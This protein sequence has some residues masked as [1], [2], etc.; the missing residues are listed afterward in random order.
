[1]TEH[2][3]V[4]FFYEHISDASG[5]RVE[6]WGK[7]FLAT[8]KTVAMVSY[9]MPVYESWY[10]HPAISSSSNSLHPLV[11]WTLLCDSCNSW[12]KFGHKFCSLRVEPVFSIIWLTISSLPSPLALFLSSTLG[13]IHSVCNN[14]LLLCNEPSICNYWTL[15]SSLVNP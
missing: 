4:E 8:Y 1:M 15:A 11:I 10:S 13:H 7:I 12:N 14:V 5:R 6:F 2:L 3:E 9:E